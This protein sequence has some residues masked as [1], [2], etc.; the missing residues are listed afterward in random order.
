M[1]YYTGCPR[2][3]AKPED[4][5]RSESEGAA[6]KLEKSL[7][8]PLTN[9]TEYDIIYRLLKKKRECKS[10]RVCEKNF[11]KSFKNLLTNGSGCDIINRLS[12][13]RKA[14]Q[15]ITKRSKAH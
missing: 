5:L 4:P 12:A 3:S 1:I 10:E 11:K 15:K 8:N 9:G 7:K 6:K 14:L 13:K 2:E